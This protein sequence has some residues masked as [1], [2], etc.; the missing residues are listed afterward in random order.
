MAKKEE[1]YKEKQPE[2]NAQDGEP[3]K[4]EGNEQTSLM[5]AKAKERFP[6]TEF[7][8][9]E[10]A[11]NAILSERD[12]MKDWQER[13][14]KANEEIRKAF[15]AEPAA[16]KLVKMIAQ[17]AGLREALAYIMDDKEL[18]SLA[19]AEDEPDHEAWKQNRDARMKELEEQQKEDEEFENNI[20][21]TEENI[22]AFAEEQ[23]MDEEQAKGFAD[24][25]SGTIQEILSGKVS[26]DTMALLRKGQNYDNDLADFQKSQEVKNKNEE[27]EKQ[28][29]KKE[30]GDGVPKL[31]GKGGTKPQKKENPGG[32]TPFDEGIDN[33]Q[34]RKV[35]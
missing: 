11:L 29:A 26:K 13:E 20:A 28:K 21:A 3:S 32:K 25:M 34:R 10:E 2:Q 1:E 24:F 27:I 7:N 35:L 18:S 6:D 22:Q 16:G 19:P 5:I 15:E 8:S 4:S 30:G 33:Y 31:S 14:M 23:G 9:D 17:G 12:E